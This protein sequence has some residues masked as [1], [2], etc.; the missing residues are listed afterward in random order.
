M[1]DCLD[2]V[3]VLGINCSTGP[4]QMVEHVRYLAQHS[5][6]PL[7]IAP[8]AGLPE[9]VN[10]EACYRLSP[11]E[12][13]R[14]QQIFVDEFGTNIAAGCCGTTPA[15]FEAAIAA[16]GQRAPKQR[17]AAAPFFKAEAAPLPPAAVASLYTSVPI[18]QEL[19]FLVVGERSNATGSRAF[20][21]LLLAE[22]LDGMVGVAKE[23]AAEGAHVIDVM[24]DYVGRN[25]VPDMETA[26][27][28][29]SHAVHAS[30][31]V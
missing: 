26:R 29:A 31:R 17:E 9:L 27:G 25:G 19:S 13:A 21:D 6:R 24:V 15:H 7:F 20:R 2:V 18:E 22:D 10:G 8:N 14:Y 28:P 5:R 30:A 11:E 1:L 12:F 3:D 4:D 16:I 23:Q